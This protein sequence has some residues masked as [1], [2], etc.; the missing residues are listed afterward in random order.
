MSKYIVTKDRIYERMF[1]DCETQRISF[2]HKTIEPAYFT[3]DYEWVAQKDV[4]KQADTVEELCDEYVSI[5]KE[6]KN[7]SL[8]E[9]EKD[10]NRYT[11]DK[12]TGWIETLEKKLK[13]FDIYGAIWTDKG[14]IHVAKM[15]EQGDLKLCYELH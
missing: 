4:T 7:H 12:I 11:R 5:N 2:D 6:S 3:V 1:P 14:L 13:R 8:I 10:G 15:N 9:I